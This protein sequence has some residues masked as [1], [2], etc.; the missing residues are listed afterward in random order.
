MGYSFPVSNT[1]CIQGSP[2]FRRSIS[3]RMALHVLGP[4]QGRRVGWLSD[5]IEALFDYLRLAMKNPPLCMIVNNII[6]YYYHLLPTLVGG[7]EHFLCFSILGIIIP[8]DSYLSEGWL[9]HQPATCIGA[10]RL[11][12][13]MTL[14]L[15]GIF[16]S[17][18]SD[19]T[20]APR[21][22]DHPNITKLLHVQL[23]GRYGVVGKP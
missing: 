11:P 17:L 8:I 15:L 10:L 1:M 4:G 21:N 5:R 6:P 2:L 20:N 23:N 3:D 13:F 14:V 7:L 19:P 9:N 18:G 16:V 12:S 22:L